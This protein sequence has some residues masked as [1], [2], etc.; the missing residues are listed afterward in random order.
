MARLEVHPFSAEFVAAAGR[1]LA[2][3]TARIARA[4]P[5]FPRG[6]RIPPRPAAEVDALAAEDEASGAVALRGDRVVGFLLGGR[7][8][9]EIWGPNVWVEL[10]GH[11]VEEA[12]DLRDLYA[13]AAARWFDEGR[14]RHYALVPASDAALVDAWSRLSFGQQHAYGIR[15]VPG[16]RAGRTACGAPSHAT[17]TRSSP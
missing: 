1:L 13:A 4:S 3:G 5:C 11:A 12:E 10:A 8:A 7:R 17:S 6:T 16:R 2:G 15:E 14:V 9:D